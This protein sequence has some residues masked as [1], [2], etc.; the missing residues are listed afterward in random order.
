MR[1]LPRFAREARRDEVASADLGVVAVLGLRHSHFKAAIKPQATYRGTA[2]KP[3]K[4]K[5]KATDQ[6]ISRITIPTPPMATTAVD[7]VR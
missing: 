7:Q 2:L 5:I 4:Q 3:P 1:Q 6:R